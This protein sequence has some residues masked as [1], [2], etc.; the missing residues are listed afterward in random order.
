MEVKFVRRLVGRRVLPIL[1]VV[2]AVAAA[3]IASASISMQSV[4]GLFRAAGIPIPSE[5]G[6]ITTTAPPNVASV[7]I[8]QGG[9]YQVKV[10]RIKVL[11]ADAVLD[12]NNMVSGFTVTLQLASPEP[13]NA[14]ISIEILLSNGITIRAGNTL[15]LQTGINAVWIQLP[16]PIDPGSIVSVKVNAAPQ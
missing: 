8:Y 1:A 11:D 16:T 15:T 12:S 5:V 9:Q 4:G 10:A 2:V 13:V 3:L 14:T 6:A 7:N